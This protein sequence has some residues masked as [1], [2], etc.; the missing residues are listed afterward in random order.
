MYP[1]TAFFKCVIVYLFI[2]SVSLDIIKDIGPLMLF[3][4][5]GKAWTC[6]TNLSGLPTSSIISQGAWPFWPA[7]MN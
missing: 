5:F 1:N 4:N 3:L 6:L 7:A 2:C